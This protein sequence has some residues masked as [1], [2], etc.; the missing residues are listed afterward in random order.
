MSGTPFKVG[1]SGTSV[2]APGNTQTADQVMSTVAITGG[3][4]LRQPFFDPN[5]FAPVTAGRFGSSGRNLPRGPGAF[6]LDGSVFRK[7]KRTESFVLEIRCEMFGVTN[8][9][10]F[11]NPGA[12]PSSLT[13]NADGTIKALNSYTETTSATGERQARFAARITF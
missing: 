11:G 3:H 5:A 13:R 1:T 9:P 8:T 10:Q 4:G 7:F 6:N 12:T 2:N